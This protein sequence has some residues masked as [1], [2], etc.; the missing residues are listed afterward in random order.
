M[1][2]QQS[3]ARQLRRFPTEA[4][5][6][7]WRRLRGR[8]FRELKFRRQLA[9]GKYIVDFVCIEKR[10]IIELDVSQHNTVAQRQYDNVR[11]QWLQSQ[12]FRILR[13]WDNEVL[14]EWEAPHPR[15][16]SRKGRGEN[17]EDWE[18]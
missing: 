5:A 14:N 4:E 15:P 11:D 2:R 1:T 18:W 7:L 6:F 16:L 17:E 9:L 8:A 12:G 10:L 13:D 3:R